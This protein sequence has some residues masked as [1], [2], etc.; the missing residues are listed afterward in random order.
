[1][2]WASPKQL[3]RTRV[4]ASTSNVNALAAADAATFLYR[5]RRQ[6][7]GSASVATFGRVVS[8]SSDLRTSRHENFLP[9]PRT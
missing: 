7:F 6:R 8:S 5:S 3:A 9:M 1:M 4:S 2:P